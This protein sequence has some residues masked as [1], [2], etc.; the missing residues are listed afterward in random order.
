MSLTPQ[1]T[2]VYGSPLAVRPLLLRSLP[3]VLALL[4]ACAKAA[5]QPSPP[6]AGLHYPAW[7]ASFEDELLV[8]SLDQDLA[9]QGGSLV[10]F[11]DD[12]SSPTDGNALGGVEVPNLA[13][14][15]RVP[16]SD[17]LSSSESMS[18]FS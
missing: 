17:E 9:Y 11:D 8:V 7:L 5:E 14:M 16:T 12:P 3:A 1:G 13:G 15:I 2:R 18:P 4:L 10:A 6:L